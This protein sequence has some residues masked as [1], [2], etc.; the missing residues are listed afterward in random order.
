MH[1]PSNIVIR[2]IGSLD[3]SSSDTLRQEVTEAIN[4]GAQ[5]LLINCQEVSFLDSSG[6]SVMVMALK[7]A[8]ETNIRLALC[9]V[10]EQAIL[11]F[12]LTGMNRVFEIFENQAAFEETLQIKS[13]QT[14]I[15]EA[16]SLRGSH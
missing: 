2:P 1:N 3:I 14:R 9:S 10:G 6:L 5:S 8:K 11:L 7:K 16:K 4:Q 15:T 13:T 12:Q